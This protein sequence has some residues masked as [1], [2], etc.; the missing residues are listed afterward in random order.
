MHSI[1]VQL[2]DIIMILQTLHTEPVTEQNL[3]NVLSWLERL[4]TTVFVLSSRCD[5]RVF[6]KKTKQNKKQALA[7]VLLQWLEEKHAA[8][9]IKMSLCL[10]RCV[11]KNASFKKPQNTFK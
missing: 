10:S 4:E 8:K 9:L 7:P 1:Y 3:S 5:V 6:K 11:F 2:I